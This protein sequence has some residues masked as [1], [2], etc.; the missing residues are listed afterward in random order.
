MDYAYDYDFRNHRLL[1]L[2]RC[3]FL[4]LRG[5]SSGITHLLLADMWPLM[6]GLVRLAVA[7]FLCK[8]SGSVRRLVKSQTTVTSTPSFFSA[9]RSALGMPESVMTR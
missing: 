7:R 2:T 4:A 5:R 8:Y 9:L 1:Q 6:D 3:A